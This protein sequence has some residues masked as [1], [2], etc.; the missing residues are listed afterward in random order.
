MYYEQVVT[1]NKYF[2]LLYKKL[3]SYGHNINYFN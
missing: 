1:R 3:C 2:D